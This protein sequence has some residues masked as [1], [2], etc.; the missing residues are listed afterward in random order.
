MVII[1]L[2]MEEVKA[3]GLSAP[4]RNKIL[5]ELVAYSKVH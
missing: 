4:V 5:E 3:E 2:Q 1:F